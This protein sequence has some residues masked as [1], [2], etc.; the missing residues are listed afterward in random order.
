VR[1]AV[2]GITTRTMGLAGQQQAGSPM[3]MAMLMAMPV[4][5]S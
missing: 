3:P 1:V 4:S 5:A 2:V